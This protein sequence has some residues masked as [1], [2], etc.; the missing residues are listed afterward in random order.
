[1]TNKLRA[2]AVVLAAGQGKRMKSARPKVLHDVLGKT[3][4][5]RVLDALDALNLE[6]IHIVLG[7]GAV[8][9]QDFLSDKPPVTA[10]STHL[11]EPQLGT[12]HALMQVVP[13]LEDFE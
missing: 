7:H 11:Q 5:T 12:G 10:W 9:V 2:R 3:I 1:M 13:S 6:H 4:L 8:E